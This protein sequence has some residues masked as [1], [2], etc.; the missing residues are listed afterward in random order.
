MIRP[1]IAGE[2]GMGME[3]PESSASEGL[4]A[5]VERPLKR[6]LL[7]M[8][9]PPGSSGVQGLIYNKILPFLELEGWE[10]HF[11]G[12]SPAL[13][14]VMTE[15][16]ECPSCRL[17]YTRNISW[18]HRFSVLKNRQR[19]N[20]LRYLFFG[21]LQFLSRI[22]EKLVGHDSRA[23][24]LAGIDQ[25]VTAAE[26]RWNYDLIAGKSPDFLILEAVSQITQRLGKPLVAMVVD[27]HGRRDGDLFTPYQEAEQRQ[28][29][30]QCCGAMFMSPL[31][32]KRYVDSG[33]VSAAKA[34]AFTDSFPSSASL[35]RAGISSLQTPDLLSRA[36][37][38][39]VRADNEARPV[40]MQLVHLGMLPEWR[41]ID[42]LL[43]A[44]ETL[45][46]PIWIDIF[47]YLYPAAQQR[48]LASAKLRRQV[49][50][51]TPVPY[52]NSHLIAEDSDA[53]LVVIGPRHLDNQPSKFF[54]Y[55]GHRK[56]VFVVGPPGNPL[57][58]IVQELGIG[59]FC[60]VSDPDSIRSGLHALTENY[61]Q[62]LQAFQAN[63]SLLAVYSAPQVAAQWARFL[64]SMLHHAD[65]ADTAPP[66]TCKKV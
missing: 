12:P 61:G 64:N 52:G 48:I 56:P 20:S 21:S 24:L 11:A 2:W 66:S 29:L 57:E 37:S 36:G 44:V 43:E 5:S 59:V 41:P 28:I 10:F 25:V 33:M 19:R 40:A 42:A 35:Y 38:A 8:M 16:V 7:V 17:H 32:L 6:I 55:L 46:A 23:Y 26:A 45:T 65:N 47:G 58:A 22:F 3:R 9:Q 54:E 51:H 49:R 1:P 53:L 13:A 31:T 50:C 15:V 18:S 30:A 39:E 63:H 60:D 14:S 34:Y 27:P 4:Q 62:I